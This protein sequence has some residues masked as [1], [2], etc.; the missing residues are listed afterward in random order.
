MGERQ[1]KRVQGCCE[2]DARRHD[3]TVRKRCP[4]EKRRR[5]GPQQQSMRGHHNAL[6]ALGGASGES[7]CR[8]GNHV[9]NPKCCRNETGKSGR[10]EN[11]RHAV[12]R[13]CPGR[14]QILSDLEMILPSDRRSLRQE[15]QR[16][17]G[18]NDKNGHGLCEPR[19]YTDF[20][21]RF[22]QDSLPEYTLDHRP[23]GLKPVQFEAG[24][25]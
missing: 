4:E 11:G 18:R 21:Q 24:P 12:N 20:C 6:I 9:A 10:T 14:P 15:E 8:R 5:H 22:H 16:D 23:T 13:Q 7:V 19:R 17:D 25:A 3:E 2:S 1:R